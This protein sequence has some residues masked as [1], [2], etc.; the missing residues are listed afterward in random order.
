MKSLLEKVDKNKIKLFIVLFLFGFLMF[1][2]G[3]IYGTKF[4]MPCE[5]KI[6]KNGNN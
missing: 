6:I 1:Q 3:F 2:I 5:I 4:Y